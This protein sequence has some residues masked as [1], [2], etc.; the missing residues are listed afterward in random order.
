MKFYTYFSNQ[1]R[2]AVVGLILVIVFL[3]GLSIFPKP[4]VYDGFNVDSESY[5]KFQNEIIHQLALN[6]IK[7]VP[8]PYPFNPNFVTDYKGYKLGM[9]SEE[10]SRLI[11]YRA[12]NK[13]VNSAEEF[14]NITKVSD[15]LLHIISPNFKFPQWVKKT[16]KNSTSFEKS[17]SFK[18][19]IDLNITTANELQKVYGVGAVLSSRIIKLRNSFIGGFISDIQLQDVRG[20][21]PETIENICKYFSVKTPRT[22]QKISLNTATID[23]LVTIQHIDYEL[24]YEIIELRMLKEGYSTIDELTKVKGFPTKKLEIIK[25]Y[26]TLN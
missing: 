6:E 22:Y 26:L 10:I 3:E 8:K 20:L 2:F 11:F 17:V 18:E 12:Q 19:K 24:A 13:W 5:L 4:I 14:Q 7:S 25:L 21:T 9:T 1:Q 15:S 23:Q 16:N